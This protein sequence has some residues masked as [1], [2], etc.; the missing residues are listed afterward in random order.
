MVAQQGATLAYLQ[1][2]LGRSKANAAP[3]YENTANGRDQ[4]IAGASPACSS[5]FSTTIPAPCD[6]DTA[7]LLDGLPSATRNSLQ[8]NPSQHYSQCMTAPISLDDGAVADASEVAARPFL[9]WPGGKRWLLD[10]APELFRIGQRRLLDPFLGGGSFLFQTPH[11]SAVAGDI[12]PDLITTYQAIAS[13]PTEVWNALDEHSRSHSRHH[14]ALQ[15][16]NRPVTSIEVAAQFIYLNHTSFNGLYRVNQTGVFNVPMG[17]RNVRTSLDE[18]TRAS[19]ALARTEFL[20]ADFQVICLMARPGDLVVL[21]PPYTVKHDRNGFV[22]YNESIFT[23][24]DQ[25][26]LAIAA[27]NARAAGAHVVVTNANHESI[28]RL[29]PSNQFTLMPMQRYSR[30]SA[31]AN[32]RTFCTE[33]VFL[34]TPL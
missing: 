19:E 9:R 17:D 23:W 27:R 2:R 34:G 29:Y 18:L 10:A 11:E 22:R 13:N 12:N 5:R 15:R 8:S 28:L 32:G 24:A 31:K 6:A 20:P 4:L 1:A 25:E 30:V 14:Y 3:L 7:H 16:S 33:A 26:R 21:D